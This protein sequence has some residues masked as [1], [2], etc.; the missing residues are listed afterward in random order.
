MDLINFVMKYSR[1]KTKALISFKHVTHLSTSNP[2]LP[3][4]LSSSSFSS[5]LPSLALLLSPLPS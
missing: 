4:L 1:V 2:P 5:F 3:F